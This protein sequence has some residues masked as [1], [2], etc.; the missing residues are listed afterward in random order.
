MP[1]AAIDFQVGALF[2]AFAQV[3]SLGNK[4][5]VRVS[6]VHAA[7]ESLTEYQRTF[8]GAPVDF[9]EAFDGFVFEASSLGRRLASADSSLH[10]VILRHAETMLAELPPARPLT[11]RV[12]NAIVAELVSGNPSITHIA[13]LLHMSPRTLGRKLDRE[14][15]A[16]S[17]LLDDMRK[18]LALRY[19]A[20]KDVELMEVAFLLGF[21]TRATFHRAFKRWTGETPLRYRLSCYDLPASLPTRT[22]ARCSAGG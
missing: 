6:F 3:W 20:S 9:G 8:A 12:R 11:E 5:I 22:R 17:L 18:S 14:G 15:T 2:R 7:P 10:D 19:L 1:R 4:G 13:P 16:F 21:S